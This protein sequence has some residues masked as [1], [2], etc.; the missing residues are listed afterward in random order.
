VAI[1]GATNRTLSFRAL[2]FANGAQYRAIAE[3]QFSAATSTV[4]TLTVVSDL[5][6]PVPLLAYGGNAFTNITI[7]FNEPLDAATAANAGNYVVT[8]SAGV[9]LS[10]LAAT[11]RDMTNAVLHTAPQTSGERYTNTARSSSSPALRPR[12]RSP[13]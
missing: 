4:A 8:N 5:A 12:V 10:V 1:A 2:R 6:G 11:V 7:E 3:N 13:R 9:A